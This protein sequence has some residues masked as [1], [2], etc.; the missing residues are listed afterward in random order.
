MLKMCVCVFRV[1]CQQLSESMELCARLQDLEKELRGKL[2]ST[3]EGRQLLQEQCTDARA[4]I[5]ALSQV[6]VS[7]CV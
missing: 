3:E 6:C 1:V 7:A 5:N 2:K 4:S